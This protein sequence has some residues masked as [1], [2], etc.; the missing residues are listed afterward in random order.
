[1]LRMSE[2]TSGAQDKAHGVHTETPREQIKYLKNELG[3]P[4]LAARLL[5]ARG[6][7]DLD[8]AHKFLYPKLEDLSDPFLLPD[9]EQGIRRTTEAI[10]KQENICLYGDY[11]ADGVTSVAILSNFFR[12]I[13]INP[14]IYIPGR[15]EGY[16][17][18]INAV[19]KF[20]EQG[21]SLLICVDCGSS[22]REEID[23]AKKNGMDVLVIDHHETSKVQPSPVA[24][25]NPKRIDSRF[26]TRELA[27]CGVA[28]FFVLALRR[29]LTHLG[30][31]GHHINLKKELDLV[32]VGSIGDMVPLVND[33]RILV[34]FGMATMRRKPRTW[35]KAFF[36]ERI[37]YRGI[38]D[39]YALN[40][41]VVPRINAA[42]RIADARQAL[43][44]LIAEDDRSARALL[45]ELNETN[46]RRQKIEEGIVREIS[47]SLAE[48][49]LTTRKSIVLYNQDWHL[50]VIGIVAQKV[51]EKFGKP[52]I[53]LTKVG[54]YL[55]GSGRGGNGIDLY[56]TVASLSPFLLKYGGHKFAC[57]IAL[58]EEKLGSFANAFEESITAPITPRERGHKAD[59]C[60]GFEEL[61]LD[62]MEFLE[63]LSPF[64]MGNPRP[65]LVMFPTALSQ[66]NR[67]VK[68]TDTGNRV[69]YGSIQ[70]QCEIPQ[71]GPLKIIAT[72]IL[73]EL[74]GEQ[75]I[76]LNIKDILPA[77]IMTNKES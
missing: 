57:G 44:F 36:S 72:P 48:E 68:V 50:G 18:N 32:T 23:E 41:I 77:E 35:L 54:D 65:N 64:G 20:K 25:I 11:D 43:E 37:I 28:F 66:K 46:R 69:W 63:N 51:M 53:I 45:A 39:E 71:S 9:I 4:D 10:Q 49:D 62:L 30:L 38:I 21:V 33:N 40:F 15:H 16:G 3:I 6:V 61:T 27:A 60:A 19:K 58:T 29:S 47:Y 67:F 5:C 12:R 17:L 59:A 75:F 34:K 74:R 1:M 52:S 42:G 7:I 22:N 76:H 55:K 8:K 26:P 24:L 14:S 13:G 31:L 70:G 2:T 73:R 56:H